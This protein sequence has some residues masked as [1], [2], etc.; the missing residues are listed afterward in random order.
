MLKTSNF[1]M[2]LNINYFLT[3]YRAYNKNMLLHILYQNTSLLK[4]NACCS[5]NIVFSLLLIVC[6][7]LYLNATLVNS[8]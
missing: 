7:H 4:C 2:L 8:H 3:K 1:N 5:R 6:V